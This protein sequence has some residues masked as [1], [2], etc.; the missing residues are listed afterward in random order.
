[1][2]GPAALTNDLVVSFA[3][4][5]R[6]KIVNESM[7]AFLSWIAVP[8]PENPAPMMAIGKSALGGTLMP[9]PLIRLPGVLIKLAGLT[10]LY[11]FCVVNINQFK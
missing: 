2:F 6:S 1:M 10:T 11:C 9:F 5:A 4:A 8:R 7:P 3:E